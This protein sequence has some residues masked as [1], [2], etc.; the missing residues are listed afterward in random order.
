MYTPPVLTI[1]E[2]FAAALCDGSSGSGVR[3]IPRIIVGHGI[4]RRDYEVYNR[5]IAQLK[6]GDVFAWIGEPTLVAPWTLMGKRSV[7]RIL[8]QSEPTDTCVG[9]RPEAR[10]HAWRKIAAVNE[11]W[12]FSKHNVVGC[13]Q[14]MARG[15]APK[16]RYIPIGATTLIGSQLFAELR[17]PDPRGSRRNKSPKQRKTDDPGPL[18]FVGALQTH[19]LRKACYTELSKALGKGNLY[20]TSQAWNEVSFA[21][22]ALQRSDIFV[23]LH[24]Q[25]GDAHNPVTW[26]N[27]T[28]L[29]QNKLILSERAHPSDESEY[30]GLVR[31]F[32]NMSAIADEYLKL[33]EPGSGWRQMADAGGERFRQRFQPRDIFARAQVYAD[34]GLQEQV[35]KREGQPGP[36]LSCTS[37]GAWCTS[38]ELAAEGH[39][40][41]KARRIVQN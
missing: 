12:D 17:S 15:N 27:P 25:C 32:D 24:K 14:A 30:D 21:S 40:V 18:N 3:C 35:Q 19:A 36:R 34:F 28:L 26:R 41:M 23:N 39:A 33:R 16:V 13:T 10:P 9:R 7:V 5:T 11:L 31:F 38:C 1:L 2:G 22:Q 20:S 6:Q 37:C 8:F 29:A 4:F